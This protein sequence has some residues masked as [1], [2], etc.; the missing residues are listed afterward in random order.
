ML[1]SIEIR[2]ERIVYE[3]ID[4]AM[5]FLDDLL[6][7]EIEQHL[8]GDA[9]LDEERQRLRLDGEQQ[10]AIKI[11]RLRRRH[12]EVRRPAR[13]H[14]IGGEASGAGIGAEHGLPV[15]RAGQEGGGGGAAGGDLR[16]R[17]WPDH[18]RGQTH[19]RRTRV[20]AADLAELQKRQRL[21]FAG[22]ND[23][24]EDH[25]VARLLRRDVIARDAIVE[26]VVVGATRRQPAGRRRYGDP[27]S[28]THHFEPPKA[29]ARH[30][31]HS[32]GAAR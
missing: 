1:K 6:R 22:A 16:R 7:E 15:Q 4:H 30:L 25:L 14:G 19:G 2:V 18:E 31:G 8:A 10:A 9:L 26:M 23:V 24:G 5:L 27:R 13:R 28:Q 32:P 21:G 20:G 12:V 29:D 11:L 17:R 3:L